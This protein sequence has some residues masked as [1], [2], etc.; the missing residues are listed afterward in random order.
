LDLES[1]RELPGNRGF[2]LGAEAAYKERVSI[3]KY[4]S[5]KAGMPYHV[6]YFPCKE[7]YI[8]REY[9]QATDT[10]KKAVM[11]ALKAGSENNE[12]YYALQDVFHRFGYY[13]PSTIRFGGRIT[14]DIVPNSD[15]EQNTSE[16]ERISYPIQEEHT[17]IHHESTICEIT[18]SEVENQ[19]VE[20]GLSRK[21]PTTEVQEALKES[22][23]WDSVGGESHLLIWN[24]IDEWIKTVG[25]NQVRIQLKGLKPLY[26]LLDEDTQYTVQQVYENLILED[27]RIY[28]DYLLEITRYTKPIDKQ[29]NLPEV[30]VSVHG[31]CIRAPTK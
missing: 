27:E 30:Y 12:K 19:A 24:G 18:E 29:G 2:I 7:L 28:Y 5:K 1:F 4:I 8:Y 23:R 17:D 10:F 3:H 9:I 6:A 25:S 21:N 31:A 26:E 11:H 13:Y 16:E 20:G 14:C 15:Q 22:D